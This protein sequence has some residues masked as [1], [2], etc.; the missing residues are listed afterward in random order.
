VFSLSNKVYPNEKIHFLV[1]GTARY[2]R[3]GISIKEKFIGIS[4]NR[5]RKKPIGQSKRNTII[6]ESR[7]AIV[8]CS[9]SK[10]IRSNRKKIP[11]DDRQSYKR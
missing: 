10:K 8:I 11:N 1:N 9:I 3:K 7:K 5:R 6:E 4:P 2:Q